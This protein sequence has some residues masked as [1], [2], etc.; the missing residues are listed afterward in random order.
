ME[1]VMKTLFLGLSAVVL[2]AAFTPAGACGRHGYT[3]AAAETHY[4]RSY[5]HHRGYHPYLRHRAV[6]RMVR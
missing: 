1:E 5:G 6:H 3:A 2:L 4:Y